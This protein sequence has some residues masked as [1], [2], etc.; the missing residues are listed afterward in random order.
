LGVLTKLADAPPACSGWRSLGR[1]RR[2]RFRHVDRR[3][4]SRRLDCPNWGAT[5][6][7]D[8]CNV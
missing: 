5:F 3:R 4:I 2:S 6:A 7:S 1:R 8:P